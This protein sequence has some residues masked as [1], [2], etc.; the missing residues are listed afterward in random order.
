M[1]NNVANLSKKWAK[2]AAEPEIEARRKMNQVSATLD[3]VTAL[4]DQGKGKAHMDSIRV[5]LK[6]FADIERGLVTI[7]KEEASSTATMTKVVL[8][9]GILTILLLSTYLTLT[10]TKA[11]TVPLNETAD[12]LKDVSRGDLTGE[13]PIRSNDENREMSRTLNDCITGIKKALWK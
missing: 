4:I 12:I 7:R 5:S 2:E 10:L 3:D 1:I 11:I 8:V 6:E 13:V 9:V